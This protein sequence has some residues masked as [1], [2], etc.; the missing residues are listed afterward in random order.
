[1]PL[2]NV[3]DLLVDP[4]LA[5][6]FTVIRR[7][8]AVSSE[9]GRASVSEQS[10]TGIVGVVTVQSPNDLERR[11][12]Y[13][14]MTRSLSVVTRFQLY[15]AVRGAVQGYQPDLILWRGT[16]HLVKHVDPYPQVGQGFYQIECSSMA[17][18]DAPV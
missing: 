2:L 4:D 7:Q 11:E 15:G 1:M 6:T 14:M 16:R 9:T 18:T 13:Q 10:F 17:N 8:E 3:S 5:D 12:D